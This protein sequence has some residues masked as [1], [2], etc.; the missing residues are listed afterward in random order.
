MPYSEITTVSL[1][2]ERSRVYGK[3]C[4]VKPKHA[5]GGENTIPYYGCISP[6]TVPVN[7]PLAGKD[8]S[9][10]LFL[11]FLVGKELLV[12][13]NVRQV[14]FLP[15]RFARYGIPVV[16]NAATGHV[17]DPR[18]RH[19]VIGMDGC[20]GQY[21]A[22]GIFQTGEMGQVDPRHATFPVVLVGPFVHNVAIIGIHVPGDPVQL[23]VGLFHGGMAHK[24]VHPNNL[25]QFL[26]SIVR[27]VEKFG[28][29]VIVM[30][31]MEEGVLLDLR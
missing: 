2:T 28:K 26:E 11:W 15:S 21:F 20:F 29:G 9:N 4:V 3:D 31:Q 22:L 30:G 18:Y 23:V 8:S 12:V 6:I 19:H 14:G 27:T 17:G 25:T 24:N 7:Q 10:A 1:Y 13:G 16:L 5:Y